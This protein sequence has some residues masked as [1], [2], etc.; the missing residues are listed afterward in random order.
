MGVITV[1]RKQRAWLIPITAMGAA[2][3]FGSVFAM[4]FS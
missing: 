4:V 2:L 1:T 3:I